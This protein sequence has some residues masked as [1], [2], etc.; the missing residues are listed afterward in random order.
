MGQEKPE[1]ASLKPEPEI[2][3]VILEL[4]RLLKWIAEDEARRLQRRY[5]LAVAGLS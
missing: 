5:A 3:E 4:G 1:W 2:N